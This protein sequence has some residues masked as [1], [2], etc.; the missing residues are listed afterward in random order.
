MRNKILV[1]KEATN[2]IYIG[3]EVSFSINTD[4]FHCT[5]STYCDPH[6]R[7]LITGDLTIIKINKLKK[8]C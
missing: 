2:S 8:K 7:C 6:Y 4:Q 3:K 1:Y 5:I